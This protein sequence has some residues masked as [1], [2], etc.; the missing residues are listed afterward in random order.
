MVIPALSRHSKLPLPAYIIPKVYVKAR[1]RRLAGG[2]EDAESMLRWAWDI[3]LTVEKQQSATSLASTALELGELYRSAYREGLLM[4]HVKE[5]PQPFSVRF[6]YEPRQDTL[7]E[8]GRRGIHWLSETRSTTM[9]HAIVDVIERYVRFGERWRKESPKVASTTNAVLRSIIKGDRDQCLFEISR[10]ESILTPKEE[11]PEAETSEEQVSEEER[12][13]G[14]I[15]WAARQGWSEII[16][17]CLDVGSIVDSLDNSHR[18]P[19]SYAAEHG[20]RDIV[21][22]L[23][24]HQGLPA[25]K[26]IDWRTPLSYASQNGHDAVVKVLLADQRV[27]TETKDKDGWLPLHWAAAGGHCDTIA[28]LCHR[29]A[30]VDDTDLKERTPFVVALE[31]A[32]EQAARLLIKFGATWDFKVENR[33]AWRTAFR[34]GMLSYGNELLRLSNE[35][36]MNALFGTG[37]NISASLL[38]QP[39]FDNSSSS[40]L[41]S[42]QEVQPNISLLNW[43]GSHGIDIIEMNHDGL[44]H[45]ATASTL[46]K[47]VSGQLVASVWILV[48]QNGESINQE[49]LPIETEIEGPLT[50]IFWDLFEPDAMFLADLVLKAAQ[51][52]FTSLPLKVLLERAGAKVE[53]T[54]EMA[55]A[56]VVPETS[57]SAAKLDSLLQIRQEFDVTS[58]FVEAAVKSTSR[59]GDLVEVLLRRRPNSIVITEN[60]MKALVRGPGSPE[61][62]EALD[63]LLR[64]RAEDVI[65]TNAVLKEAAA[66]ESSLGPSLLEKLLSSVPEDFVV[67]EEVIEAAISHEIDSEIASNVPELVPI[68]LRQRSLKVNLTPLFLGKVVDNLGAHNESIKDTIEALDSTFYAFDAMH[69]LY[70]DVNYILEEL[71]DRATAGF[72]MTDDHL[73]AAVQSRYCSLKLVSKLLERREAGIDEKVAIELSEVASGLWDGGDSL[74]ELIATHNSSR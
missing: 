58:D 34:K 66:N 19:L 47:V 62:T 26:D 3:G 27:T 45:Y 32:Q 13:M 43:Q 57:S 59:T 41:L 72:N 8:F 25:T 9:S 70:V 71:L 65:I 37:E 50:E 44:Q 36:S 20:H 5:P 29:K 64:E 4:Q 10:V 73:R 35:K 6:Y 54:N 33:K 39:A 11:T 49:R 18:T 40:S 61:K 55:E 28:S 1:Q 46:S 48:N 69:G 23:L 16:N 17:T 22:L 60:V 12:A 68:L 7:E 31:N 14:I 67:T 15:S 38:L 42:Y 74:A 53:I 51:N 56:T 24:E 52:P 30:D 2:Y 21:L 63:S